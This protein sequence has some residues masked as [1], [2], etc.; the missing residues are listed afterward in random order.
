MTEMDPTAHANPRV[1]VHARGTTQ[2]HPSGTHRALG[3]LRA[4]ART[5]TG[6]TFGPVLHLYGGVVA[7]RYA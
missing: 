1:R 2:P 7:T 6:P 3:Y 5:P 4:P